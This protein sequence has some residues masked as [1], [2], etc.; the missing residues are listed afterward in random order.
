MEHDIHYF[1]EMIV[2]VT[3]RG[4]RIS[5]KFSGIEKRKMVYG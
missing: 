2:S 1:K 5:R 4:G 3:P